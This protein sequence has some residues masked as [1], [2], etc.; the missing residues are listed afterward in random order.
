M[1]RN[2]RKLLLASAGLSSL[3]AAPALAQSTP[4]ADAAVS[5]SATLDEIVV[6]A[7]R[8]EEQ[9]QDVP[10][11][12]QAF[13]DE[14]LEDRRIEN[15]TDL[16]KIV[17][18]LTSAQSSRNEE[19]YV[20]RAMS[21]SGASISGQQVTVPTYI[22]QVPLPIGDGGGPGRYYDLQNIQVL[23]GPQGT[24]FG[25]NS[26]G[27]AVLFEPRR[28]GSEFDGYVEGEFG[29]YGN[30]GIEGA[31][32]VPLSESLMVRVAGKANDRDGFTRNV[33]TNR[34]EDDRHYWTGRF[35]LLFAPTDAFENIFVADTLHSNTNGSSNH[36]AAVDPNAAIPRLFAGA[37]QAQLT[38]QQALGP[39]VSIS[40]T[41]AKNEL[42]AS[43]FSNITTLDLGENLTLK[44][45]LG[46]RRVKQLNRFDFDGTPLT[47]LNFD[48]CQA[49]A[50]CNPQN[51]DEPWS[52]NVK[53]WSE[54]L[55]L[56][57]SALDDR[58]TYTI[59]LF[60]SNTSTPDA[61]YIHQTSVFGS[62]TDIN[63]FVRDRSRAIYG[64][65]T[66]DLSGLVDGLGIT[67]GY[68]TT[69]DTR[70]LTIFQVSSFR[71]TTG[72][73][74]AAAPT[75]G[76]APQCRAEFESKARTDSYTIG[77][78]Y[79]FSDDALLYIAHRKGYRAGGTNPLAG[80]ALLA[81]PPIP[82]AA[83]L[84]V[85]QPE[86]L[87]DVELGLKADWNAGDW[88]MRSNI[89]LYHQKLT[90]AQLNQTFSVGTQTVS[91]L[92]NASEAKVNGVEAELTV[93]PS[94]AFNL[95]LAYAYTDAKYGSFLD[96]NRRDPV[97]QVPQR[98]TGRIIPFT[99]KHK[100]NVGASLDLPVPE[101][102]G[103]VSLS[104]NL[105]YKSSII[106]GL[107]PFLAGS[108]AFDGESRQKPTTTVDANL[109]WDSIG[110]SPIDATFFVTNLFDT[111]Y[112]IGGASL[113]NSGLGFNQ[114]IY[115]EPRMYGVTLRYRFGASAD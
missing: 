106:L 4:P 36:I 7:R 22:A 60:G 57:G 113:I 58:L 46:Y 44:N 92:V 52:L 64:Q 5:D 34:D 97:T 35:S 87:K 115:N 76:N 85:Y 66:Y 18:A 43:G 86:I 75:P 47:L 100:F 63:Q 23:K 49:A 1:D 78:D 29:N 56:Q 21:G 19:N 24:L 13:S 103:E 79:R 42:K 72:T 108:N 94:S 96:Y 82:N 14:T 8:R 67:G 89:A 98:F 111:T 10:L 37:V 16:S 88:D 12:I 45:I 59:G 41:I 114:R 61:N 101:S 107:V 28:P 27:G 40:D 95:L 90:G 70:G 109:D 30:H 33:T 83:D 6:T 32:N 9:L 48:I 71:C 2:F 81:T 3:L 105:A 25:R 38:R 91:A 50:Q 26:T 54:E 93:A 74:G 15:A 62:T 99:P 53:Q 84:F 110:G 73:P 80:P 104:A 68:R 102:A 11:A 20:I 69:K 17:P 112:K 51:P 55:Q 39:Y 77:L 31:L 65:A